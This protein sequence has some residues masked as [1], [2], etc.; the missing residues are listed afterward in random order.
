[1]KVSLTL[2]AS[3]LVMTSALATPRRDE[4]PVIPANMT[5]SPSMSIIE[6]KGTGPLGVAH[7]NCTTTMPANRLGKRKCLKPFGFIIHWYTPRGLVNHKTKNGRGYSWLWGDPSDEDTPII[8]QDGNPC[9][10]ARIWWACERG[11][12]H[13]AE[14]Y[15]AY[16]QKEPWSEG[17]RQAIAELEKAD[18]KENAIDPITGPA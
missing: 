13:F 7:H 15:L 4:A 14:G 3:L 5:V 6:D 18:M 10:W 12:Q 16:W 9:Y 8:C 1:M 17:Q 2:F 11:I